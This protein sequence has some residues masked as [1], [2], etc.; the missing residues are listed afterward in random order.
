MS[1]KI[2]L[3]RKLW[4]NENPTIIA[5]HWRNHGNKVKWITF[6]TWLTKVVGFLDDDVMSGD[7]RWWIWW[8]FQWALILKRSKN[9]SCYSLGLKQRH[10]LGPFQNRIQRIQSLTIYAHRCHLT[11]CPLARRWGGGQPRDGGIILGPKSRVS[12]RRS[13]VSNHFKYQPGFPNKFS[14]WMQWIDDRWKTQHLGMVG[15]LIF[16]SWDVS[17]I[18]QD[19][20]KNN[21]ELYSYF[22]RKQE[23]Q[24]TKIQ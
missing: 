23:F 12:H 1:Q 16:P 21:H 3:H 20:R 8:Y 4:R 22:Q 15:R 2:V 9:N 7:D 11:A 6:T 13:D 17:Q 24:P 14:D 10:C 18:R 5:K 19:L